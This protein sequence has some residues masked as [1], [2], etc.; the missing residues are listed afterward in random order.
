[1]PRTGH[2]PGRGP[3]VG[4]TEA[5]RMLGVTRRTVYLWCA[6]G[7]L[8][9]VRNEQDKVRVLLEQVSVA[10]TPAGADRDSLLSL[11]SLLDGIAVDTPGARIH[12]APF[13]TDGPR[14]ASV[15]VATMKGPGARTATE[16]ITVS[17]MAAGITVSVP[18]GS[19]GPAAQLIAHLT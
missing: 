7:R 17:L 3:G 15:V 10:V 14:Y 18:F 11:R 9:A 6:D 12:C 13:P 4:V 1:M 19:H 16:R 5:A 2:R 8:T